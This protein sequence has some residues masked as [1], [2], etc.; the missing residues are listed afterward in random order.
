M[1]RKQELRSFYRA[2]RESLLPEARKLQSFRVE[3]KIF[4]NLPEKGYVASYYSI[5]YEL[6]MW[7][8]NERLASEE[9]LVLP[10]T[11]ND[12]SLRLY[13][14]KDLEKD[15]SVDDKGIPAPDPQRCPEVEPDKVKAIIVPGLAFDMDNYRL[16]YGKGCYDKLL[17]GLDNVMKIGV[18]FDECLTEKL[19]HTENDVPVDIV[20][21]AEKSLP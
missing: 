15:I 1:K 19:P 9:R 21:T 7:H 8:L 13:L 14:V 18:T 20:L 10:F 12:F 2:R 16:G 4:F 17:A 5:K 6:N 11:Q 3:K